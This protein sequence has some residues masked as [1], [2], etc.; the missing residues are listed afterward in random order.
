MAVAESQEFID[1]PEFTKLREAYEQAAAEVLLASDNLRVAVKKIPVPAA[2]LIAGRPM[3]NPFTW[4]RGP[5][6][7]GDAFGDAIHN[8]RVF[9]DHPYAQV[10]DDMMASGD[11]PW[12]E[13]GE[14][15]ED[16]E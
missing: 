11:S 7:G 4:H 14:D 16:D 6:L 10:I 9:A 3:R 8:L 5:A 2:P 12:P 1:P 13:E 15:E